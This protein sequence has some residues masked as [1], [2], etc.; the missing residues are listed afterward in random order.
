MENRKKGKK[1]WKN[2]WCN[3]LNAKNVDATTCIIKIAKL[4]FNDRWHE[5][6]RN[7]I[8]NC[9]RCV[10]LKMS[11][12]TIDRNGNLIWI[13]SA[14]SLLHKSQAQIYAENWAISQNVCKVCLL[15]S[16]SWVVEK[17]MERKIKKKIEKRRESVPRIRWI[18]QFGMRSTSISNKQ[19]SA[20]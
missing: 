1:T 19:T 16:M 10:W 12:H 9:N 17:E 3:E 7:N 11:L 2:K 4:S 18:R 20:A 8:R 14:N 13:Q 6:N 15:S 5:K